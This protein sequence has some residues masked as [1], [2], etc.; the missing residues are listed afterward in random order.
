MDPSWD[1][2]GY[3]ATGPTWDFGRK[4]MIAL[5]VVCLVGLMI[6]L[7]VVSMKGEF[8]FWRDAGIITALISGGCTLLYFAT[9]PKW[10]I[11]RMFLINLIVFSL[12]GALLVLVFRAAREEPARLKASSLLALVFVACTIGYFAMDPSWDSGRMLMIALIVVSLGGTFLLL[13]PRPIRLTV[14]SLLILYHFAGILTAVVSV[15]PPGNA[16]PWIASRAWVYFFR[17]YLSFM[18]LNNAYHFYSPEPGPPTLVWSYVIYSNG[19]EYEGEWIRLPDRERSPVP[20]HHQRLLS[21]AENTN[22]LMPAVPDLEQRLTRRNEKVR[23]IPY[24]PAMTV[25]SQCSMPLA[26]SQEVLKAFA[27]HMARTHPHLAGRPEFKFHSVKVYRVVHKCLEPAYMALGYSPLD[28]TLYFAYFQGDFTAAG[29]LRNPTDPYLYWLI[30]ILRDNSKFINPANKQV[31]P[32]DPNDPDE[33]LMN[34]L[35]MHARLID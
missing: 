8:L 1:F 31:M 5:I 34:Y 29:E 10:F 25:Q 7:A 14:I 11:E 6:Y 9:D 20:L 3:F 33:G 35:E 26:Y 24:H 28:K 4:L 32:P 13:F 23:E 19:K 12:W 22:Q 2:T 21:L 30:P 18:Y 27:R 15:D 16:A 17:P